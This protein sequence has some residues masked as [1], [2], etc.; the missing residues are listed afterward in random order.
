MT[1]D[2]IIESLNEDRP[3]PVI[4]SIRLQELLRVLKDSKND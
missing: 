1:L 2:E 4:E 3:L